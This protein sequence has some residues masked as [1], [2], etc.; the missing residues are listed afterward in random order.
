MGSISLEF[1]QRFPGVP[2]TLISGVSFQ[3]AALMP[4]IGVI[5]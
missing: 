5:S 2:E 1:I 4:M 3:V